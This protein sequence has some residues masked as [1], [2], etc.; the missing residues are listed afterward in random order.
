MTFHVL[1]EN[2]NHWIGRKKEGDAGHEILVYH[3]LG[4]TSAPLKRFPTAPE[5]TN[6]VAFGDLVFVVS[7]DY[8]EEVVTIYNEQFEEM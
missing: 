5:V 3:S 7:K 1:T 2:G 4:D 6:M 8:D